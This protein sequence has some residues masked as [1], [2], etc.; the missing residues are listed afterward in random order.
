MIRARTMKPR[1][2]KLYPTP[3]DAAT[4]FYDAFER[5][6]L[7]A[8]MAVWSQ[9][10]HVVCIHPGGPRL[11]GFEAVRDSWAQLFAGGTRLRVVTTD[12]CRFDSPTIAVQSV[13]EMVSPRGVEG[14]PTPISATNVFELTESGWRLVIHHACPMAEVQQRRAEDDPPSKK[15]V[16]H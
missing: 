2:N 13:V 8:M 3:E 1:R 4:A 14:D 10:Q 12:A 16:L 9:S 7:P 11:V 6:D 15:H 5:A